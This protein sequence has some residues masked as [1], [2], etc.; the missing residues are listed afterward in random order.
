VDIEEVSSDTRQTAARREAAVRRVVA[1]PDGERTRR[2][3]A[4]EAKRLGA[5]RFGFHR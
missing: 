4:F 1:L 2:A 3:F 5:A